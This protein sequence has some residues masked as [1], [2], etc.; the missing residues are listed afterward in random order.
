MTIQQVN[1]LDISQI[2]DIIFYVYIYF[3]EEFKYLL[4]NNFSPKP[5]EYQ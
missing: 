3:K 1:M 4:E 2:P 5:L